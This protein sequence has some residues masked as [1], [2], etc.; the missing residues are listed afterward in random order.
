MRKSLLFGLCL[1][2]LLACKRDLD[3]A[4]PLLTDLY[5]DFRVL[6][7]LSRSAGQI[8]FSTGQRAHFTARVSV[9]S[10]WEIQITGRNSGAVKVI[11]GRSREIDVT[12]ASWGGETT[13]FPTF[14]TEACDVQLTFPGRTDTLRSSIEVT[15]LRAIDA[16]ILDDFETGLSTAWTTFVQTGAD[17]KFL[18]ATT[19]PLA[20]GLQYYRMGGTVGWDWLK[21]L[22]T[23]NASAYNSTTGF[24]LPNNAT[25]VHFN[26]IFRQRSDLTNGIVL[27]QFR[28]DEN[29]DGVFTPA[30]EDMWA[31]EIRPGANWKLESIRYAD[32]TALENGAP[33]APK[34][35]GVH[36]PQKLLRVDVLF[37]ANPTSGYS[38]C[39]MDLLAFSLNGPVQP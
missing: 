31:I 34:G 15:G 37:L 1:L 23:L 33:T 7:P 13:R 6:E 36:E 26:G 35:N 21:G 2:G 20:E 14:Q 11:T 27:F 17:M 30:T 25:Q 28:E 24:G 10:D 8:D 32:L 38:E 19:P 16:I 3:P 18:G 29:G 39:D 12:N 5:G 22:L 9:L 4:G